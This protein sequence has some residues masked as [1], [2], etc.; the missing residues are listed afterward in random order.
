MSGR[1]G[2]GPSAS[3]ARDP[4]RREGYRQASDVS[5]LV[6]AKALVGLWVL[7][8][9]FTHVSDDDYARVVIA[10][11]FA[12]APRLDPSGTSWLPAPFWVLGGAMI[13][14]G[15]SLATARLF[16]LALG[17]GGVAVLYMALRRAG[18][19]R[20]PALMGVAVGM[21]TPWAAW[22]GVA[23][24]PEAPTA[25]LV[26]SAA[27]LAGQPRVRLWGAV[28]VFVAALSRYESWPVCVVVAAAC[29]WAARPGAPP[30]DGE[31][32]RE[33]ERTGE[34]DREGK[35]EGPAK[36]LR[37][38]GPGRLALTASVALLGPVA[39]MLWNAHAH[40]GPLHFLRR[41]TAF[42]EA[43]SR[44]SGA[45]FRLVPE[46]VIAAAPEVLGLALAGAAGL[47]D[48]W[49]RRRWF[50]PL[51]AV[52]ASVAFLL[53]GEAR[54]GA[55]T[56]H[57]E[58]TLL[59]AFLLLAAFGAD[60]LWTAARSVAWGRPAREAWLAAGAV[61]AVLAWALTI[62]GRLAAAPGEGSGED[63]T[64]QIEEGRVLAGAGAAGLDVTPCAYEH[65]A[66]IAAYG[67]PENAR[68]L[69][70]RPSSSCPSVVVR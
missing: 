41:V 62:R 59:P 18:V 57:F 63:R 66:L 56:H 51:S 70:S 64:A 40:D 9:G 55:P 45:P 23:T 14:F 32:A 43:A 49:L 54:G 20:G 58:R 36:G 53:L 7:R 68:T 5:L 2:R 65:F 39:W 10:Q 37:R 6:V 50:W 44:A 34:T 8:L 26:A 24:V 38:D 60:G 11:L 17:C 28:A 4:R 19:S 12:H 3:T 69:P 61:A 27:V 46:A 25:C 31:G 29:G 22:L 30:G 42:H 48:P 15:R 33:E 1:G 52:G 35:G 67:A 16:A 13:V 47:F 21:A